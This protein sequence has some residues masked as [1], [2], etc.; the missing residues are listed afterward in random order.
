[1][2]RLNCRWDQRIMDDHLVEETEEGAGWQRNKTW[3]V[4]IREKEVRR[5]RNAC[6]RHRAKSVRRTEVSASDQ[7]RNDLN[8]S[9]LEGW[10]GFLNDFKDKHSYMMQEKDTGMGGWEGANIMTSSKRN[11]STQVPPPSCVCVRVCFTCVFVSNYTLHLYMCM[12]V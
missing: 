9:P 5:K 7:A 10:G 8:P 12:C 2:L 4:K 1:M 6:A 3:R 11:S